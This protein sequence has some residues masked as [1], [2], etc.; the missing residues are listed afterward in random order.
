MLV[1]TPVLSPSHIS[2]VKTA[3][4]RTRSIEKALKIKCSETWLMS[5]LS[6]IQHA[7][8][9]VCM[10]IS[11]C[12]YLTF[13]RS[14]QHQCKL[15]ACI[16]ALCVCKQIIMNHCKTPVRRCRN[17]FLHVDVKVHSRTFLF[18]QSVKHLLYLHNKHTLFSH[19]SAVVY[20]YWYK[21]AFSF[22]LGLEGD[23]KKLHWVLNLWLRCVSI[24]IKC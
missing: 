23:V 9:S 13:V 21:W 22:C 4:W 2:T 5:W 11:V 18:I 10:I 16:E 17:W 3:C 1:V 7:K 15:A 19:F 12:V 24:N 14:H 20:E 6:C 8:S